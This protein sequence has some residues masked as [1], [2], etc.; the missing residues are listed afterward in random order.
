MRRERERIEESKGTE[1]SK[2]SRRGE[3]VGKSKEVDK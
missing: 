3:K 1:E 2:E